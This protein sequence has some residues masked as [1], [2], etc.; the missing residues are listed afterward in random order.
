MVGEEKD[1]GGKGERK[2]E[3]E[4]GVGRRENTKEAVMANL[5]CHRE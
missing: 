2:V 3:R 5:H 4:E 1:R